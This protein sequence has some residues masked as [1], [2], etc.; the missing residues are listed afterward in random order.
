MTNKTPLPP[1]DTLQLGAA[2]NRKTTITLP[3]DDN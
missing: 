2:A 3:L 1:F